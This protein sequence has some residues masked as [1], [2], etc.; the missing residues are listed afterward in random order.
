MASVNPLSR[1]LVFKIV[2]YGPGLGGKTTTLEYIHATAKP[3]HRGK[4]V[5]LATPV[6]RTLYFDFLPMR[7]PPIRGMNVRLQLFTVPGQVYF[8]ATRKLVLTGSDGIVFVSDSQIARADANLESFDNLRDNLADQGRNVADMPIVFQHNK[9]DLPDVL[10]MEEL[11]RMLNRFRA[12]SLPASAKTGMGV[13]ETLE[14]ITQV[15]LASFESQI[16]ESVRAA[17]AEAYDPAEEGLAAALRDA[18][19]SD[20]PPVSAAMVNRVAPSRAWGSVPPD[21]GIEEPEELKSPAMRPPPLPVTSFPEAQEEPAPSSAQLAIAP[22]AEAPILPK[23]ESV[24]PPPPPSVHPPPTAGRP[25]APESVRSRTRGSVF[26]PPKPFAP[27]VP[28]APQAPT[29]APGSNNAGVNFG[30]KAEAGV[31]AEASR[32]VGLS[33]A[34]LWSDGDH[35]LVHNVEAAIAN[36]RYAEAIEQCDGLVARQ[37]ASAASLFG[38]SD[39]PRDPSTVPLMLGLDG[40]R[41][42]S[43]RSTVRAAR[44][45]VKMT[46]RDALAAY[47]FAI[48]TRLARSSIR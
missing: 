28:Q 24:R 44:G 14:R 34:E 36:G 11:D 7:L 32:G 48:D 47:A 26:P 43:F 37:L 20:R 30:S 19:R 40:R 31:H 12:P 45:G 27:L 17:A 16:P 42:L 2:Y 1:E 38:A 15:V 9:R 35:A 4:L 39:A 22:P 3:E 13:Y 5:S 10:P 25:R 23:T 18:S 29:S 6:D 41:Y 33:F 21:T 46:A 8:N